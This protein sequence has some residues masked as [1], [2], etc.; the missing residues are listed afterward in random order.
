MR[1]TGRETAP[2]RALLG[3]LLGLLL[4]LGVAAQ[5]APPGAEPPAQVKAFVEL[6]D[7]PGVRAWLRQ[8]LA[9]AP[10]PAPVDVASPAAEPDAAVRAIERLREHRQV[11]AAALPTLARDL[12]QAFGRLRAEVSELG[13]LFLLPLV[14]AFVGAGYLA[15]YLFGRASRRLRR[16]VL[17]ASERTIAERVLKLG[18]RLL[19][20]LSGVLV[21]A[22]G[23]LG[24]FLIFDWPPLFRAV[25]ERLLIAFL[26]LRLGLVLARILLQPRLP[27]L[28]VLPVS[29]AEARFWYRRWA[30]F[31]GVFA[32]GWAIARSLRLLGA[33]DAT[34]AIV[35]YLLGIGLVAVAI[36]TIAN[37][38]R[39]VVAAAGEDENGAAVPSAVPTLLA[40]GYVLLIYGLWLLGAMYAFWLAL[41]AGVLPAAISVT[42]RAVNNLLRPVGTMQSAETDPPS[43]L[44]AVVERGA[45]AALIVGAALFLAWAWGIDLDAVARGETGLGRIASGLISVVV[46][47]LLA[48][49]GWHVARTAIDVTLHGATVEGDLDPQEARRRAR[50]RTLLPIARN[51][52]LVLVAVTAGLMAL[53][54]LGVQIGPLI[55]GAG[56]IGVAVGFGAQ[57][58]VKDIISGVFY[59][60][61]DAFRVGEYIVSGSF[62]GTVESFSLRSIKL[63]HH[64]GA[65]FTV[66]FGSLGAIQNLSR[67][68]VIDKLAVNVPFDTDLAKMKAIV[69]QIGKELA[70]D[71]ELAPNIIEPLKLQGVQAMGQFAMEVR[72]KMKTKPGEQF[73]IRRRAWA[74]LMKRLP[75]AGIQVALPTVQVSSGEAGP[76]ARAAQALELAEKQAAE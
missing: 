22:L 23:S 17:D 60:L 67:D 44:A 50:L 71:P 27:K 39:G 52:L 28:R 7:D 35:A 55:A 63:R 19:L 25:A 21:F 43:I 74:M 36:E 72:M 41:V 32:F 68:W 20:A 15:E 2:L 73:V 70:A 34:V 16:R 65:L 3:F 61:D 66:P 62:K 8:Q 30:A 10:E 11:I 76:A 54:S 49:F 64:R 57:T 18:L 31:L 46:I 47:A 75:E 33:P 48:D 38:R 26:L 4:P 6:L 29:D 37:R 9:D 5:E 45:R 58:L 59:L 51:M 69:K 53:A 13:L 1:P 56:V 42:Q 12:G 24:A 14:I 40:I